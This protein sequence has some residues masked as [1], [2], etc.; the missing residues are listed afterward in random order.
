MTHSKLQQPSEVKLRPLPRVTQP[1]SDS[2]GALVINLEATPSG[3]SGGSSAGWAGG[4]LLGWGPERGLG[5]VV[6]EGRDYLE[7]LV[8]APHRASLNQG[9]ASAPSW[10]EVSRSPLSL[11]AAWSC[12]DSSGSC[13]PKL[14][15]TQAFPCPTLSRSGPLCARWGWP[16]GKP[17]V[18]SQPW[19]SSWAW[20]EF[21]HWSFTLEDVRGFKD[22]SHF[23]S[24]PSL[25]QG[26]GNPVRAPHTPISSVPQH[27]V[28]RWNTS[29][30]FQQPARWPLR[31]PVACSKSC[32]SW[33]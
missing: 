9:M 26:L 1:V 29:R 16:V 14:M 18:P 23:Q 32:H 8:Q 31:R 2:K 19:S 6:L 33:L 22:S 17:R 24:D 21:W 15:W 12:P 20:G 10:S 3:V 7:H 27:P 28:P 30:A 4:T 13:P 5:R 11:R 25:L